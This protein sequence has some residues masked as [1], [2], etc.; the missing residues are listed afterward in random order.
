M[1]QRKDIENILHKSVLKCLL[2]CMRP[3]LISM[4]KSLKSRSC[5]GRGEGALSVCPRTLAS[6]ANTGSVA[7]ARESRDSSRGCW[8]VNTCTMKGKYKGE[9]F[10]VIYRKKCDDDFLLGGIKNKSPQVISQH[11]DSISWWNV[12][13]S[14]HCPFTSGQTNIH[15]GIQQVFQ[16]FK[17]TC[18]CLSLVSCD[19]PFL[20]RSSMASRSCLSQRSRMRFSNTKIAAS[21][22]VD[23]LWPL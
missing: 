16:S 21:C 3:Y 9:K 6:E 23:F 1:Q 11:P 20:R 19:T 17:T 5:G 8:T 2:T 4:S 7:K 13:S 22:R 18:G 15:H 12:E 10:L 14:H